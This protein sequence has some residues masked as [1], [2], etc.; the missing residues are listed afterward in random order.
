MIKLELSRQAEKVISNAISAGHFPD[1]KSFVEAAIFNFLEEQDKEEAV[2]NWS[3]D[4]LRS[5]MQKGSDSGFEPFER[6]HA[7]TKRS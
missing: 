5:A 2:E 7:I 4:E 6:V 1:A 3:L